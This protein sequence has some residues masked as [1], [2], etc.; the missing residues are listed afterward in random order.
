MAADPLRWVRR[1]IRG[2]V[3]YQA[4]VFPQGIKLDANENPFPWPAVFTERLGR[5]AF[6]DAFNRY[7]DGAATGLR[8]ALSGYTGREPAEILVSNGSDEAI[9]LFLLT[10]GGPGLATVVANP[11]FVMYAMATR[12]LGGKVIDVPLLEVEGVFHLD[13]AGILAAAA[14]EETRLIVI[15]NPNNPTGNCFPEEDILAVVNGTDKPV[16]VD[17]AYYEFSGQTLAPR[18]AELPNLLIMRTFSKAFGLAGL[19]VGY[20]L[21]APELIREINKVRQ[22]FNVNAFSQGAARLALAEAPAFQA[23]V[24]QVLAGRERLWPELH[25]FAWQVYPTDANFIFLRPRAADLAAGVRLAGAI[26]QGLLDQGIMVRRL[27]DALRITIGRPVEN[28]R[29]LAALA[30]LQ[31]TQNGGWSV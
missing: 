22:P 1:D 24:R 3:P 14:R 17:E 26:F 11:T 18:L 2:I 28:E 5:E 20:T 6:T 25:R 29:L 9:Q 8:Q 15:C 27:G 7:P 13:V 12:Y 21:G 30:V 19:R 31:E 16:V 23:Q 4:K 10:F